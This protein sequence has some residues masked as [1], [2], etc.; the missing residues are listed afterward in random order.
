MTQQESVA[1]LRQ[2]LEQ[3]VKDLTEELLYWVEELN[4]LDAGQLAEPTDP[5]DHHTGS[6]L[7]HRQRN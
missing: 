3:Y 7:A 1:L 5:A 4:K 2:T 6:G